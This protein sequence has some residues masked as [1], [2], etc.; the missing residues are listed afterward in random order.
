M[1]AAEKEASAQVGFWDRSMVEGM[2]SQLPGVNMSE[3]TDNETELGSAITRSTFAAPKVS[4][5]QHCQQR[6]EEEAEAAATH[7]AI[8]AAAGAGSGV[9]AGTGVNLSTSGN[10][11]AE[12]EAQKAEHEEKIRQFMELTGSDM[13]VARRL[14]QEAGWSATIAATKFYS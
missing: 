3:S 13:E 5:M 10:N 11:E 1:A 14:L 9:A 12:T 4:R 6:D 7:E 2:L 8:Q